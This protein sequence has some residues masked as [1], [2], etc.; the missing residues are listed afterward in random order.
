MKTSS[1]LK[2]IAK[3]SL[4]G[5]WGQAIGAMLLVGIVSG[6]PFCSP[7]ML[8]GSCKYN[9][10]LVRKENTQVEDVFGGFQ[11]FGKAL[12]LSIIIGFFLYLWTLLL[13][14]PGFIK[15]FSY[16]MATYV[17]SENPQMTAREALRESKKIMAGK[18][19]K[20]FYIEL[21]FIGW[22]LLG[23]ISLGIGYLWILPY[24]SATIAAFYNEATSVSEA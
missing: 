20:L 6:V 4:K 19:G 22:C 10:K 24:M 11:I 16:S 13:I 5:K 9:L 7:A 12:W 17:L 21:S 3:E 2:A 8:V 15:T 14:I 23:T 1:E 18:K